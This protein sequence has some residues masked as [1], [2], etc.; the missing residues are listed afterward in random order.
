M[1]RRA[2]GGTNTPYAPGTALPHNSAANITRVEP[3][4]DLPAF[5]WARF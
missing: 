1:P 4:R 3:L 5:E 2:P